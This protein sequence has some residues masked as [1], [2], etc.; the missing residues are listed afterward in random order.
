LIITV[1]FR[2]EFIEFFGLNPTSSNGSPVLIEGASPASN[3]NNIAAKAN[4]D[5]PM[6]DSPALVVKSKRLS[7]ILI[8]YFN[9]VRY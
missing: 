8:F 5:D 2:P 9:L 6:E 4:D 3:S 7:I 1:C